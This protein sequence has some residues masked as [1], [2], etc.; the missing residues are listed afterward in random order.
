MTKRQ[1][2]DLVVGLIALICASLG[3]WAGYQDG[4][5]QG[6]MDGY[7]CAISFGKDCPGLNFPEIKKEKP[8]RRGE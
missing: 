6:W 5:H 4:W 7:K 3:C 2:R 8:W 1:K